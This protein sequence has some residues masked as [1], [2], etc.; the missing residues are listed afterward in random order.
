ML[1]H[2]ENHPGEIQSPFPL[3][4]EVLERVSAE[5][6]GFSDQELEL[7]SGSN[8]GLLEPDDPVRYLLEF[9]GRPEIKNFVGEPGKHAYRAGVCVGAAIVRKS[10]IVLNEHGMRPEQDYFDPESV[11]SLPE[12][13]PKREIEGD[14]SWNGISSRRVLKQAFFPYLEDVKLVDTLD[15]LKYE[16]MGEEHDFLTPDEIQ[17]GSDD[18]IFAGLLDVLAT[19]AQIYGFEPKSRLDRAKALGGPVVRAIRAA[20]SVAARIIAPT[21]YIPNA[22]N[23]SDDEPV[24]LD[25]VEQ[26]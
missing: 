26:S 23:D 20:K 13:R 22:V 15:R 8:I 9:K 25:K 2:H 11:I 10:L 5:Y 3:G 12:L 7:I 18:Y 14:E 21:S 1:L 6:S 16:W 17:K 4:E 19:Y 24:E